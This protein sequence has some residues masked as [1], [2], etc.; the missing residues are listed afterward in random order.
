MIACD[1]CGTL[2]TPDLRNKQRNKH[3]FCKR[4]CY[5]DFSKEKTYAPWHAESILLA[6]YA[7]FFDAEGH[8]GLSPNAAGHLIANLTNTYLPVLQR[9]QT[10]F[11]PCPVPLQTLK[12]AQAH[13]AVAYRLNW[14]GHAARVFLE[15]LLPW[16]VTKHQRAMLGIAFQQLT[17]PQRRGAEGQQIKEQ[18]RS[19][20]LLG[21]QGQLALHF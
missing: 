10:A 2:Y 13:H 15:A 16:L 17:L 9:I 1:T 20:N 19:F 6:Y 4:Q 3:N 11:T 5:Y 8:V 7:G 21:I 14:Q 12:P 18:L